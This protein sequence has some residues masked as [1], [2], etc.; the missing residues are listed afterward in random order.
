[1][2]V[3]K[4]YGKTEAESLGVYSRIMSNAMHLYGTSFTVVVD[5]KLLI[6]MYNSHSRNNI[7]RVVKHRSKLR[8]FD[9]KVRYEPGATIEKVQ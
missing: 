6:P 8:S 1:M 9:F 4:A 7:V 2:E 5:H 3:E